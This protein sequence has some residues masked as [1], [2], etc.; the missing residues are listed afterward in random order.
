M[1]ASAYA[2]VGIAIVMSVIAYGAYL[3]GKKPNFS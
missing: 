2:A 3:L 1:D